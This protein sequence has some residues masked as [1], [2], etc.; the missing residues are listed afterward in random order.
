MY[1]SLVLRVD[2]INIESSSI[3]RIVVTE[4]WI[5]KTSLLTIYVAN[6]SDASLDVYQSYKQP[7]LWT[8]SWEVQYLGIGIKSIRAGVTPFTI[9]INSADFKELQDRIP[10]PI[11]VLPGVSFHKTRLERFIDAF[12]D[13]VEQ[14]ARF[15]IN[16]V[17][18][19]L[20]TKIIANYNF[21]FIGSRKLYRMHA[22]ASQCQTA[23]AVWDGCS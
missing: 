1:R 15:R 19:Y 14:N 21:I 6:Q 4:N 17:F 5:I 12:K 2:K 20:G 11:R 22:D 8:D 7:I 10:R 3:T 23:K 13:E 16:E 9:Q 18:I